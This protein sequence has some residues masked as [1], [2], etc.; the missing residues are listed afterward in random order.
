MMWSRVQ[1]LTIKHW[2]PKHE[3]NQLTSFTDCDWKGYY[4]QPGLLNL[5]EVDHSN[6]Q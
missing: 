3:L 2:S 1:V 6:C 5:T 4:F